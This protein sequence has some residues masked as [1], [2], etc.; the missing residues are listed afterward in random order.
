MFLSLILRQEFTPNFLRN[1]IQYCVVGLS[2]KNADL[3]TRGN[4]SLDKFQTEQLLAQA[5]ADGLNELMV[6]STCNR[7]ELMGIV[8]DPQIL[9]DY[10]CAF[11]GGDRS[12]FLEIGFV[13]TD[14]DAINH[15][16]RVGCGLE[17][18]IVG[19][20]EII[21]QLK[22]TF[23]NS[24]KQQMV[25]GFSERL[26][27]AVIQSSKRIKTETLLSS[28]ATSVS[29]ASVHY[30]LEH[31]KAVS[32]KN[33]LLFGTGKIGR[34]T[35]ENLIKHTQ[36]DHIVLV[37]RSEESAQRVAGK[38]NL[39]VKPISGLKTEIAHSDIL[40]VATG[41]HD[42]TVDT[43]MVSRDKPL[44]ILDLSVP[45]NVDPKLNDLENITLVNL[46]ELS[47]LTNDTLK[48]REQFI[49]KANAILNEVE[50][51]FLKWVDQRKFAP[52]LK[53]LKQKLLNGQQ[54]E[55]GEV[56]EFSQIVYRLTGKVASYLKENPSKADQTME[57]LQY[58][59]QLDSELDV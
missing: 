40:I 22:K 3:S 25:N 9:I 8:D 28:G 14:R 29:F 2:Y 41:A 16:F 21:G 13:L 30:I 59:Y 44:L 17:S 31:V 51:E 11:S 55:Q 36:N 12:L 4:F 57:L 58:V 23:F 15:V 39:V 1:T 27:N 10:L 52:T 46:D 43:S 7:T 34:N 42:I 49:P 18:Q 45:S 50:S 19:D 48:K 20:F 37:N 35:C 54:M 6:I 5:K 33:I 32:Q 24:K 53:A 56:P 47:Q 26:V 38:F